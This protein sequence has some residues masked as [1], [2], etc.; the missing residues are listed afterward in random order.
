MS[1][2]E[3]SS[4]FLPQGWLLRGTL[5][6]DSLHDRNPPSNAADRDRE[7]SGVGASRTCPGDAQARGH[8]PGAS[9]LSCARV[10]GSASAGPRAG[11][12]CGEVPKHQL[13][14]GLSCFLCLSTVLLGLV[15]DIQEDSGLWSVLSP[16]WVVVC[17][18]FTYWRAICRHH[19]EK[20]GGFCCFCLKGESV[21]CS[22]KGSQCCPIS[23]PPDL[24]I[25]P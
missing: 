17:L 22:N 8:C 25:Y 9:G 11:A 6:L 18:L 7:G 1:T 10:L 20:W 15:L 5:V 3:Q 14:V 21:P 12:R 19:D 16:A 24:W 2:R 4:D 13:T 23:H